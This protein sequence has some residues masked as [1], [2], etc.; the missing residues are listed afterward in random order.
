MID[1]DQNPKMK[2]Y[3]F[4]TFSDN[5]GGNVSSFWLDIHPIDYMHVK[6]RIHILRKKV[7]N[8]EYEI[9]NS[10]TFTMGP[11]WIPMVVTSYRKCE[12]NDFDRAVMAGIAIKGSDLNQEA[13][14]LHEQLRELDKLMKNK[15]GLRKNQ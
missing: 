8:H 11:S 15:N 10:N 1:L 13:A 2:S 9:Q 5:Q 3:Y 6:H 7:L 4:A 14:G 12:Y